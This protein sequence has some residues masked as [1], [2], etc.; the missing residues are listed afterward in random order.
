MFFAGCYVTLLLFNLFIILFILFMYVFV[1]KKN[2][3]FLDFWWPVVYLLFNVYIIFYLNYK[4][5]LIGEAC[6]V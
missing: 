6:F 1:H 3:F 5:T 4:S 2:H